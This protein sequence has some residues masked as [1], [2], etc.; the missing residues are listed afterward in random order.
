LDLRSS[1]STQPFEGSR[2]VRDGRYGISI[3]SGLEVI[4]K[5]SVC[6]AIFKSEFIDR[7]MKPK[8]TIAAS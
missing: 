1:L 8:L 7:T 3:D 2:F 6:G 5:Q 4:E